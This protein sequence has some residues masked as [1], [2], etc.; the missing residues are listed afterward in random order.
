M[1]EDAPPAPWERAAENARRASAQSETFWGAFQDA[2]KLWCIG[3]PLHHQRHTDDG[4]VFTHEVAEPVNG[5]TGVQ[6]SMVHTYKLVQ[7]LVSLDRAYVWVGAA[8]VTRRPNLP[9]KVIPIP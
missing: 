8:K 4:A 9:L 6:T 3:G 5:Q 7:F 1:D 2:A